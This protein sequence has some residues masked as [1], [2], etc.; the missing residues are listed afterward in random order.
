MRFPLCSVISR[1]NLTGEHPRGPP[2][3]SRRRSALS[4]VVSRRA[5]TSACSVVHADTQPFSANL[6]SRLSQAVQTAATLP[7][8]GGDAIRTID[9]NF[10]ARHPVD[11]CRHRT[12]PAVPPASHRHRPP[13]CRWRRTFGGH[14]G[15]RGDHQEAVVARPVLGAIGVQAHTH[16]ESGFSYGA[17]DEHETAGTQLLT[18]PRSAAERCSWTCRSPSPQVTTCTA[19]QTPGHVRTVFEPTTSRDAD[20][21][22]TRA[23]RP[24][25]TTAVSPTYRSG[26]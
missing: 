22:R 23:G 11:P 7:S 8:A 25:I 26:S 20:E 14:C 19:A 12:A 17:L 1:R 15:S 3:P 24:A 16:G 5:T 18:D 6:P 13:R 10:M 21:A 2:A 4:P 9:T